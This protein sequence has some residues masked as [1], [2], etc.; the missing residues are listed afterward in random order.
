M[1]TIE[2]RKIKEVVDVLDGLSMSST[3]EDIKGEY[4]REI[5]IHIN[6]LQFVRVRL[7][8]GNT[9]SFSGLVCR[10]DEKSIGTINIEWDT[11]SWLN[12]EDDEVRVVQ[13][14]LI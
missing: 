11:F 7:N 14:K 8:R 10:V 12:L 6:K 4:C 9:Y 3:A 2:E 13:H 1:R 5:T